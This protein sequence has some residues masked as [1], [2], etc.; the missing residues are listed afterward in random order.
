MG[1]TVS[2]VTVAQFC[3]LPEFPDKLLELRDGEVVELTRPKKGHWNIQRKLLRLLAS[4]DEIGVFGTELAFRPTAEH[5]LWA[6]DLAFVTRE[7]YWATSDN[8]NLHGSPDLVIEVES[9][10]NTAAEFEAR[11]AKCLATGCR[12]F[13]V[14]YPEMRWVHVA[15]QD[16]RVRRYYPGETIELTIAPGVKVAVD[17]I[18]RSDR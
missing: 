17:E 2:L 3:A 13:W 1:T 12:E 18:F 16:G 14:V 4:L 7:R 10:S 11:E 6:A 5:N 15:T 8:D 9:P